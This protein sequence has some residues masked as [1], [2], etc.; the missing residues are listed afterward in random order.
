MKSL[1][2]CVFAL[3]FASLSLSCAVAV[4]GMVQYLPDSS[5]EYV[6]YK[7][8][9][10][11][12]TSYV[13]F[14]YYDDSTYALR[15][16]APAVASE[17]LVEKDII[18]YFS[19]N[20]ESSV[21]ELTGEK[22][23]GATEQSD[24]DIVNYMHDLFYEFTSRGQAAF[25][26]DNSRI[27]SRQDFAQ[28]GGP[29]V[30]VFNPQVPL[31]NI[32]AIKSASGTNILQLMTAGALA[33][34]DDGSFTAY[35]GIEGLPRDKARDFK[36]K[37]ASKSSASFDTQTL[38]LDSQWTQ[39]MDNLWWLGDYAMAMM[40]VIPL[41]DA[42]KGNETQ[43]E[44]FLVR[45]LTQSTTGSY[46]LWPQQKIERKDGRISLMTVFYQPDSGDVTR[47]FKI[48]VKRSDG[49]YAFLQLTVFDS[50]YQKNKSY[51]DGIMKSYSVK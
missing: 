12:R 40:N 20:P 31:F 19:V 16:Y 6:Y 2:K 10:F 27:E 21:L 5:G 42:Y 41:P 24:T 7:D 11:T 4:P 38:S 23:V 43:F 26:T 8:N 15:Y 33:A 30:I 32:E 14:L 49:S 17:K 48:L 1:K 45:K 25:L 37:R 18:L 36:K 29:V 28:F 34:S 9:S 46:S 47:D 13:G 3:L 51:F 50:V 44:D 22:I 35:K 39:M